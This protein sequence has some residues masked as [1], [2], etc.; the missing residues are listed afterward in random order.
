MDAVTGLEAQA[1][2]EQALAILMGLALAATCGIRAFLPLFALSL[3]AYFGK[4]E[5]GAAFAWLGTPLAALCFGVAVLAELLGDKIPAVDHALDAAG[6][7]VKP[8]AATL[9]TASVVTEFDPMLAVV[10]G[11]VTG[12]VAAEGIH[13]TKAK[14]RVVS[15]ALTG[16]IA[17]PI[18]SVLEDIAAFLGVILAWVVPAL[19]VLSAIGFVLTVW[20]WRRSRRAPVAA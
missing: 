14:A 19:V 20:L 11:L 15:S 16:T 6:V 1:M 7:V 8:L 9:A 13:L 4:V 2:L 5:L 3:L 18:L 10:L 17:N 12:G